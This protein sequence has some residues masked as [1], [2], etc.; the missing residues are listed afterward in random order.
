MVQQ[1]GSPSHLDLAVWNRLPF[2]LQGAKHFKDIQYAPGVTYGEMFLQN[3]YEMSG[4]GASLYSPF[5]FILVCVTA[6]ACTPA[7][8]PGTHV[9]SASR[10]CRW[11]FCSV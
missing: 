6:F 10:R 1:F 3:E 7:R 11:K 2:H 9:A 4:E 5:C 8:S